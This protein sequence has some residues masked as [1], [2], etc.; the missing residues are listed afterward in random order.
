M[1]TNETNFGISCEQ[2]LPA[3]NHRSTATLTSHSSVG[4]LQNSPDH[5]QGS[6]R[7]ADPASPSVLQHAIQHTGSD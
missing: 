5:R 2:K 6:H 3:T 7:L 1:H 4:L